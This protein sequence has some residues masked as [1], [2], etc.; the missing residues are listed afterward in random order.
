MEGTKKDLDTI[1]SN[2]PNNT[3]NNIEEQVNYKIKV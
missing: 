3:L 1:G 2:N